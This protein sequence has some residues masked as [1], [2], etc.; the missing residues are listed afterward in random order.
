MTDDNSVDK[1]FENES[2]MIHNFNDILI[3]ELCIL[4]KRTNLKYT[5]SLIQYR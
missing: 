2:T 1:T 3:K 4:I 5:F